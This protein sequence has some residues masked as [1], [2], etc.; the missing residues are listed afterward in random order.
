MTEK[1]M[2]KQ[3]QELSEKEDLSQL[4]FPFILDQEEGKGSIFPFLMS[5]GDPD[6][7]PFCQRDFLTHKI[8]QIKD[9]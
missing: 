5:D 9:S 2:Q 4:K 7:K 8:S 1:E 6:S 3:L